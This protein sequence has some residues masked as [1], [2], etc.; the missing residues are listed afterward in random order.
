MV[1]R[2]IAMHAHNTKDSEILQDMIWRAKVQD[3]VGDRF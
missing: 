3:V 2:V 1:E